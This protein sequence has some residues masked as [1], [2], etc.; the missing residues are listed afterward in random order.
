[1]ICTRCGEEKG[2]DFRPNR[3][4]CRECDNE[5]AREYRKQLKD[6]PK[7]EF[8]ICSQCG[9][10]KTEFRINRGK[11]LDCERAHGREYRQ[12]TD[13]AKI[14]AEN[15][16]ERM[17]ELQ[18]N[19]YDKNREEIHQKLSERYHNDPNFKLVCSHRAALRRMASA[20]GKTSI[21]MDCTGDRLRDW[22]KFQFTDDMS[23]ENYGTFWVL[24]HVIPIEKFL[25]GD[26]PKEV[27]LSWLN[28]KPVLRH[29]NLVK[30][31]YIDE[32]QC[33][34]HHTSVVKYLKIRKIKVDAKDYLSALKTFCETSCCGNPLRALT[35]TS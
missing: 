35:T 24:D 17:S 28:T 29:S 16:K 6:Q 19:W 27:I 22:L 5:M 3:K 8:I 1:M 2:T 4:V 7:P 30:N 23:F 14:W 18:H 9:E 10:K 15:N 11:C 25:C 12:T 33:A 34:E 20:D 31:K 32:E 21:Y 26:Y 13:K